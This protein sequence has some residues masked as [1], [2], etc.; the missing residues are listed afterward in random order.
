MHVLLATDHEATGSRVRQVLLREGLDCP[1]ASL[2]RLELASQRLTAAQP[3]LIVVNLAPDPERGLG[4]LTKLRAGSQARIIAVGPESDLKLILS[5]LRGGADDYVME[6]D[7]EGELA[8]ALQRWRSQQSAQATLGKLIAVVA[9]SGG[10]GSSTLAANIAA[11]LAAQHRAVA[12]FDMKLEQ[13]DLA[14]LLDLKPTYSLA[15]VCQNAAR[16]DR[17]LFE[18]SLVRHSSGVHLLAAPRLFADI[19]QVTAEGVRQALTLA[20]ATFP[21]VVVDLHPLFRDE[22]ASV[23]HQAD[24]ILVVLRLDFASLR[25][26]RRCLDHLE[27]LGITKDRVRLVVN[28]YGQPHEVPAA[29]AEEAL[30]VKIF[31]FIPD[32]PKTINR[33]NNN[34]VPAVLQAPTAKVSKS[35]AGLAAEVNGRHRAH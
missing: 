24:V 26:T 5:A 11:A 7:L 10:S 12:L 3:E 17:V 19:D 34:G 2:V 22:P 25:N 31:H 6:S 13:G 8:T 32:D 29:K 23:I 15:D 1:A 35:I 30:G 28:R 9:P 27:R 16:M 21:Y 14:A 33:A 18:R 4:V 20:R